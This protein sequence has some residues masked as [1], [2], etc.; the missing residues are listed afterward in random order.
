MPAMS[1]KSELRLLKLTTYRT[2]MFLCE[3]IAIFILATAGYGVLMLLGAEDPAWLAYLMFAL[4][5][6]GGISLRYAIKTLKQK[7]KEIDAL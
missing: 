7:G 3:V 1:E 5:I 6:V 4:A 2:L